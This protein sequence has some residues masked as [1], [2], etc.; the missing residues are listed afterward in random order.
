MVKTYGSE[1]NLLATMLP[2]TLS[3]LVDGIVA[4][5]SGLA[6]D[7]T[8]SPHFPNLVAA[9]QAGP[10]AMKSLAIEQLFFATPLG[11]S[12]TQL[13]TVGVPSAYLTGF[14]DVPEFILWANAQPAVSVTV[15][16]LAIPT[17]TSAAMYNSI[18][19]D[20]TGMTAAHVVGPADKSEIA[21][22]YSIPLQSAELWKGY[23]AYIMS[24]YG[25]NGF[26][27]SLGPF[28]GPTSGGMLVKRSVHEWIFGYT[29]PVVSPTYAIN[30][31]RRF[32]RSVTKIRDV[33][34]IEVDHVPWAVTDTSTWAYDYGSTPYRM[35][36]GVY[37]SEEA[38]DILQRSD[39]TGNITYPHSGHVEKVIGKD[40]VSGQYHAIKN[41]ETT[42]DVTAWG[43]FGMGLDLKRSLTLRHQAGRSVKKN[44]KVSVETYGIAYEEFLP[45]PIN[46]TSCGRNTEYHGSFNISG[47]TVIPTVYTLP[48]GHRANP[49][50]FVGDDDISS[51]NWPFTPNATKHDIEFSIYERTGNTVGMRVPIQPN[52]KIQPTDV[53]Y[54]TLW[55]SAG[56]G[57]VH[58]PIAWTSLEYDM[59][60]EFYTSIKDTITHIELLVATWTYICPAICVMGLLLSGVKLYVRRVLNRRLLD[61]DQYVK[62]CARDD[63]RAIGSFSDKHVV[64]G[65]KSRDGKLLSG[66]S[67]LDGSAVGGDV[68]VDI[69]SSPR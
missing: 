18:V 10:D 68:V 39:G 32:I 66:P 64:Q 43:D 61:E 60:D 37:S 50:V 30:D 33:S 1:T 56:G 59:T 31:P 54:T 38:T 12:I 15:S 7:P 45:C 63:S 14:P 42:T 11:G 46:Q 27:A 44:D 49:R 28:L 21:A 20:S 57:D 36:T 8:L 55:K 4:L 41:L 13:S 5:F 69:P 52:Y 53:F 65:L 48:H 47:F 51:A 3:S 23:L 16:S 67:R 29:D 26:Q 2:T 58:F 9:L 17:A 34:T 62:D 19:D 40:I 6:S 22:T 25:A 24:T 35:A